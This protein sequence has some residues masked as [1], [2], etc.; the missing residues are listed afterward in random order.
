MTI[1]TSSKRGH[2]MD[3]IQK[4]CWH[5]RTGNKVTYDPMGYAFVN[6]LGS[7]CCHCGQRARKVAATWQSHEHAA[8]NGRYRSWVKPRDRTCATRL[9]TC[10]S[11]W[12]WLTGGAELGKGVLNDA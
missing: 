5:D 6:M 3:S 4:H 1:G 10:F 7:D 8:R 12:R 2:V 11:F 9:V